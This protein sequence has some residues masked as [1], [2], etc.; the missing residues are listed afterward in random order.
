MTTE[1]IARVC[2][3][4]NRAY[5]AAIGDLSQVSWETAP[6]WQ[7]DSA[8]QGVAKAQAGE[9]PEALHESWSAQKI[10]AGWRYGTEK[11][12]EDKTHPRLV[13]YSELPAEQQAKDRLFGAVVVA[14]S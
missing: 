8:V 7:R 3:E 14:L 13:P 12:A 11:N 1:Q 2:H 10:A 9:G 4:A 5:C 6:G